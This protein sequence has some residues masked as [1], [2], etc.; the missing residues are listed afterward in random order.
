MERKGISVA[1]SNIQDILVAIYAGSVDNDFETIHAA[2]R[3][4]RSAINQVKRYTFQIGDKVC[5]NS[6]V[7]PKYLVGYVGV[8][9]SRKN[10]NFV[11]KFD[12]TLPGRYK[13]QT[14][15]TCPPAVLDK[16]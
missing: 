15:L 8:I 16:A 7:S 6:Q 9:I 12:T 10:T 1:N 14:S 2:I 13:W 4:R 5:L 3:D 11:V